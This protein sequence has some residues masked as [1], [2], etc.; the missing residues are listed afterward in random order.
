M[1]PIAP[2]EVWIR[3]KN[4]YPILGTK[5]EREFNKDCIVWNTVVTAFDLKTKQYTFEWEE[6]NKNIEKENNCTCGQI[7]KKLHPEEM[8]RFKVGESIREKLK[9]DGL[10]YDGQIKPINLEQNVPCEVQQQ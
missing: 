9:E 1:C 6:K 2:L 5:I 7:G 10:W 8:E 3:V 4:Y